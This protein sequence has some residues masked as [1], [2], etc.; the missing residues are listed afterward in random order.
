M[1]PPGTDTVHSISQH[2]ATEKPKKS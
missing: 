1:N 2:P